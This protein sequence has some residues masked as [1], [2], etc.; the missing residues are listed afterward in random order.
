M[1]RGIFCLGAFKYSD[2]KFR[3]RFVFGLLCFG[4]PDAVQIG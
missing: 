2:C 1:F 4:V 3:L